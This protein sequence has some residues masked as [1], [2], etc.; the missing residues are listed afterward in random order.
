MA[1][2]YYEPFK[3]WSGYVNATVFNNSTVTEAFGVTVYYSNKTYSHSLGTQWSGV[4][5]SQGKITLSFLWQTSSMKPTMNYTITANATIIPGETNI[6]NNHYSI[7]AR[8]R[9]PGD[10]NGDGTVNIKDV[11]PITLYWLQT[12]PPGPV[13]ADVNCDGFI[14]IK[15]VTPITL[16]W[17]KT[18]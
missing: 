11:T 17:L 5:A 7:I 2:N 12:V 3:G 9:G 6:Q 15:D 14:N 8:I 13:I 10:V 4:V 16:N 18:Y 1:P